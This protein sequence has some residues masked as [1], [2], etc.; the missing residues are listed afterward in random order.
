VSVCTQFAHYPT[1][2]VQ[3]VFNAGCSL[4]SIYR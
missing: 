4:V 1:E 2:P 3:D